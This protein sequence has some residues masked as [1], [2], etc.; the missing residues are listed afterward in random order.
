MNYEKIRPIVVRADGESFEHYIDRKIN[1]EEK[2]RQKKLENQEREIFMLGEEVQKWKSLCEDTE[3]QLTSVLY[4][5]EELATKPGKFKKQELN[6]VLR[7]AKK[8]AGSRKG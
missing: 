7:R 3:A 6:E 1:A 2:F 5:I 8:E 4:Q